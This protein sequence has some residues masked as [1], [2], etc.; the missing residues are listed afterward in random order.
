MNLPVD[1]IN[2]RSSKFECSHL[3]SVMM[4]LN[5][6]GKGFV[7]PRVHRLSWRQA[8]AGTQGRN[9]EAGIGRER[10]EERCLRAYS[11]WPAWLNLL[12]VKNSTMGALG[13]HSQGRGIARQRHWLCSAYVVGMNE[14]AAQCFRKLVQLFGLYFQTIVSAFIFKK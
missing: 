9:P 10:M 11:A 14:A 4:N 12:A 13:T 3:V 7:Q 8:G 1:T 6:G 5:L 2:Q